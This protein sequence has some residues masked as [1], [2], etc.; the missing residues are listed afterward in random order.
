[1]R[2][3]ADENIPLIEHYFSPHGNLILKPGR[4]ITHT[5]LIDA[6]I[7]LIRSITRVNQ[8]L[9]ENT[10]VKFVG[11]TTS[12]ADH[13]DTN[14]L[15][16]HNIQWSVAPGAN[17]ATVAE[18]VV[19]AVAA[20]QKLNVLHTKKIRA[21]IVGAGTIGQLVAKKLQLFGFDIV[22]CDPFRTDIATIP[23]DELTDCDLIS[24][25]TP[26]TQNSP[27]P[28]YHLVQKRFLQKQK[29]G[30]VLLNVGRGE[31]FSFDQL[32][33]YGQKLIWA[34]D[35]WE[36]EPYIDFEILQQAIIATP[37]IAGYSLQSKYR[38]IDMIY[39]AALRQKIITTS[40]ASQ[41]HYPAKKI[42]LPRAENWR[43]VVLAIFDP[44]A[45]TIEMKEYLITNGHG[46]DLLRKKYLERYEF[47][48]IELADVN[49]PEPDKK[50]LKA[51]GIQIS[52]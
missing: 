9:L 52:A 21:G 34:L 20:L 27:H 14:W 4:N 8:A 7:L 32:K 29:K 23:F 35:V 5:D 44:L 16:A 22:V 13:L 39:Q 10:S 51:L 37:H 3:V 49:L 36:N 40:D 25:H 28:T 30:C 47:G 11:S 26:L 42:S 41:P 17:A 38:S 45:A 19:C 46:F 33:M 1:M 6:D 2:I 31:V 48:F 24:F 50:F 18:Y 43:D 15:D 12:G